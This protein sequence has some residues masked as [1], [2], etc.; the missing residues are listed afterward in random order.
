MIPAPR[1]LTARYKQDESPLAW[2]YKP[3]I[4]FG[5]DGHPLIVGEGKRDR[6]LVRADTYANYDGLG[7]DLYP[8]IVALLPAGGWR[9]A[10]SRDDGQGE[11]SQPL[12][13]WGLKADGSVVP[14][15]TDGTGCVEELDSP[16]GKYR[17]YHP[18]AEDSV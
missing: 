6:N 17:V 1:G 13:G 9:V 7:D 8:A 16:R 15:D 10:W 12:V 11:W 3:V 2:D 5:D 14:L 18:G 4:A